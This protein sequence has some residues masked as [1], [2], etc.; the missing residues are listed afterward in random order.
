MSEP[1]LDDPSLH[2][3]LDPEDMYARVD[4]LAAQL[5]RGWEVGASVP[6]PDEYRDVQNIVVAGMGGSAIGGSLVEAYGAGEIPRPFSVWRG[7]GV[8][9]FVGPETLFI[10]VSFS[11]ETE[12][13]ISGFTAAHERGARVMAITSGGTIGRLAAAWGVPCIRFA[14]ASQ[15]RSALGYLFAPLLRIMETLGFLSHQEAHVREAID[16][17]RNA[18]REWGKDSPESRNGAKQLARTLQP[19]VP[20]VYGAELL[21]AVARRWKTQLNE[22]AKTWA[23]Y[24]EFPE[25]DHNAIVGYRYPRDASS[26]IHVLLLDSPLLSERVKRRMAVTEEL[27]R[28]YGVPHSRIEGR[29]RSA[30]A[31]TLSLIALGDYVTYYLALLHGADP[32]EIEP[33]VRLKHALARG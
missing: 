32:T 19:A 7:Y 2:A 29:G 21:S 10:A 4:D 30:L 20:V 23:F 16:V 31:Q 27:M 9:G 15:P 8:P 22:N 28:D 11:G 33:I 5:E 25:L 17:V 3:R 13:T 1:D 24:E 18:G 26:R 14:Y 6:I 12:E